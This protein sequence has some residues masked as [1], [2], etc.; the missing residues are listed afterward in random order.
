[1][2][3]PLDPWQRGAIRYALEHFHGM[4][5]YYRLKRIGLTRSQIRKI[6][7]R[8]E[9]KARA[10]RT[11]KPPAGSVSRSTPNLLPLNSGRLPGSYRRGSAKDERERHDPDGTALLVPQG[12]G[13]E[14][15]KM[16]IPSK[17]DNA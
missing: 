6:E 2:T 8:V 10:E 1:M 16:V 14:T 11:A 4:K 17:A 13:G 9:R 3:K 12:E 5:L 7:E 15:L